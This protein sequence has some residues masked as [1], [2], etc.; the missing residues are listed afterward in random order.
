MTAIVWSAEY[1]R[2]VNETLAGVQ[3]ADL[4]AVAAVMMDA[5][6]R[7]ARVFVCGNGGSAA[8]ASHFAGDLNKGA[9][10]AGRQRFR[11]LSLVD[12]TTALMAWSND[13]GYELGMVEQL[14]NFVEPGDVVI[15]ISGSGNSA[16][17][18][19][20]LELARQAGARTVGFCGFDG[21]RMLGLSDVAVHVQ[22]H[23]MEQVED[24]FSVVCHSLLY[25]LRRCIRQEPSV[26][27]P[28]LAS[29]AD[30]YPN[31]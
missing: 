24:A 23:N 6:R 10:I 17:V 7:R 25:T 11:A 4:A 3:P 26:A 31:E 28:L 5:W 20:A 30:A 15:G 14:R 29:R 19:L 12:N 27:D 1:L 8:I 9:N 21:G 22:S 13:E 18:L 16:N 2:G